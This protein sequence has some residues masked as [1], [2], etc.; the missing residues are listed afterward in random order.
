MPKAGSGTTPYPHMLEPLD[1]GFITLPNRVVMGS[2]HTRLEH[3]PDGVRKLAAFYE[4][5]ARA[6]VGLILTAAI[7]PNPVGV[8]TLGSAKLD[9]MEEVADH[10]VITDAV[11]NAGGRICMQILHSGRNSEH[12]GAIAPSPIK[13]PVKPYPPREMT[14]DDIETTFKAFE[15]CAKLAR[16]AGY[17]GVEIMASEGYLL[18]QFTS[19]FAN[20]RTDRWGGATENRLRFPTEVVRRVRQAVGK[21]FLIVYRLSMIDLVPNGTTADEVVQLAKQVEAAGANILNSGIGWHEAAVPT[22]AHMVPR[23]GWSWA[24]RRV[25]EQ[26]SIPVI[27]SNRINT[28]DVAEAIIARG[29]ADMVSMA[30]PF[31]ADGELVKK[32]IEGRADEINVCIACNQACLDLIFTENL[33]SCLVNP[34]ACHETEAEYNPTPASKPRNLAVVG[35]GPAGLTY[36]ITAAGRG[37]TVT[38]YEASDEIGGQLNVAKVIPGKE[39]FFALID[40]FKRKLEV[41]GVHVRLNSAP[42]AEDL[43]SAQHDEIIISTGVTPRRPD[44]EGI[45][46]PKV[47]S[48]LDVLVHKKR[49]GKRVAIIGAG[50]IGYDV[51]EFLI[52]DGPPTSLD[53]DAFLAEWGIEREGGSPGSLSPSGPAKPHPAR[54]ITLLQRTPGKPGRSLGK[55]TGW[56]HKASLARNKVV[57][58][59]GA[60]YQRIDEDGLHYSVDGE[61]RLLEADTIVLCTGQEPNTKLHDALKSANIRVRLIGGAEEASEL[62]AKRAIDQGWR[63]AVAV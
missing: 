38:L 57:N 44:I 58:V 26:V 29:D 3:E 21:D 27:A 2:M 8:I 36:A 45:D 42:S 41:N 16:E 17:D 63:L 43:I 46:H 28:P 32:A 54:E 20:Q 62:D 23:G 6:N 48:Y 55:T 52:H 25:K 56:V 33:C 22:I 59:T 35:S 37:H 13:S 61:A 12:E 34:R 39:E 30:R 60:T 18:N 53:M 24:T 5:R 47:L 1:F 19:P 40:Y 9:S 11:H 51:A 49:V 14:E 10:R 50:G 15:N 4:E 31:L 7:S